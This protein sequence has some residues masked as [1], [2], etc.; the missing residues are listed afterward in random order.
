MISGKKGWI[1]IVEAFVAILLIMGVVLILLNKGYIGKKDISEKVYEFEISGLRAVELNDILREE[2]L[3]VD[4]ALIPLESD[5]QRFPPGIKSTIS[6]KIPEN[7]ECKLKICP[8][9]RICSLNVYLEED[10]YAQ[11]V[12]IASTHTETLTTY[13][14]KQ[15]KIFCWVR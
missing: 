2:L 11:A 13:N 15:L 5:N 14:P 9:E 6:E 12:V 10:I 7:F 3:S 8:P 4:N 1:R